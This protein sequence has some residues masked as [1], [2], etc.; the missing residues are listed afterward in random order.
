MPVNNI[1]IIHY[2]S[3]R[4]VRVGGYSLASFT[5]LTADK[6]HRINDTFT[7]VDMRLL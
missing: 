3:V 1:I 5:V 6:T 4:M 2:S 7:K